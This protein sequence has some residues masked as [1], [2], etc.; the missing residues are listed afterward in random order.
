[1]K[2]YILKPNREGWPPEIPC[3][4]SQCEMDIDVIESE[5]PD[6]WKPWLNIQRAKAIEG[7]RKRG[8][9]SKQVEK[10]VTKPIG[11]MIARIPEGMELIEV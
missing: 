11:F 3:C 7:A 6:E 9:T 2:R 8:A 10:M 5:L 4:E 1:M